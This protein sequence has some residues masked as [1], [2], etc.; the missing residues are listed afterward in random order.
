MFTYQLFL[1]ALGC[2]WVVLAS[3]SFPFFVKPGRPLPVSST[4]AQEITLPAAVT[5]TSVQSERGTQASRSVTAN[6]RNQ[7]EPEHIAGLA[8]FCFA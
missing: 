1:M 2:R 3:S 7:G 4:T 5:T 6:T 8:R